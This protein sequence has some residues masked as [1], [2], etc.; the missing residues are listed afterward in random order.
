MGRAPRRGEDI[1]RPARA[2]AAGTGAGELPEHDLPRKNTWNGLQPWIVPQAKAIC[3]KFNLTVTA[4]WS[5]D[6]VHAD[7]SDHKWGGAVDLVG[8][9]DDM[10]ACTLWADEYKSLVYKPG[11]VFRWVGGPAPDADGVEAGHG[12]HVH[13]SWFLEGPGTS[14]FATREFQV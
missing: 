3:A 11:V 7:R 10:N 12:D 13:L 4:G 5:D 14:I 2:G 8:A 9:A 1:P 6:T